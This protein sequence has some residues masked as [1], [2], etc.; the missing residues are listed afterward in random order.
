[1]CRPAWRIIHTG[2]LS[3]FS[4]RAARSKSG[5]CSVLAAAACR[6]VAGR[7]LLAGPARA[8]VQLTQASAQSAILC[9]AIVPDKN[10]VA[11]ARYPATRA[12]IEP[13]TT[14]RKLPRPILQLLRVGYEIADRTKHLSKWFYRSS[15]D[16]IRS[17]SAFKRL[18]LLTAWAGWDILSHPFGSK[19]AAGHPSRVPDFFGQRFFCLT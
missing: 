3:T 17:G 4:P 7:G 14:S 9:T 5:S 10:W 13:L 16:R 2:V 12:S 11:C 19:I 1:M 8:A 6:T 15:A 18:L